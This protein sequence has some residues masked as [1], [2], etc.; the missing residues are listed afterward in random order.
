MHDVERTRAEE[1]AATRRASPPAN[2]TVKARLRL[3]INEGC[4]PKIRPCNL[5]HGKP[6]ENGTDACIDGG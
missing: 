1:V 6:P 3:F 5:T 2:C 4:D